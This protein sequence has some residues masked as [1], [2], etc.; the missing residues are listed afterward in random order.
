[1]QVSPYEKDSLKSIEQH[2]MFRSL[3]CYPNRPKPCVVRVDMDRVVVGFRK[4]VN[5]SQAYQRL[6]NK[7]QLNG[8]DYLL[9]RFD[10]SGVKN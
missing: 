7:A 3:I 6:K 8:G 5:S 1:M 2:R 9:I 10:I 4:A